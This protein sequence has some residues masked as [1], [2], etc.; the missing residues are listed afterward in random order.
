MLL[1]H[2]QLAVLLKTRANVSLTQGLELGP[3]CGELLRK[4]P[5]RWDWARPSGPDLVGCW[6]WVREDARGATGLR[7]YALEG[8][9]ADVLGAGGRRRWC[10]CVGSSAAARA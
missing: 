5:L 4:M 6:S 8:R 1:R 10:A 3:V 2:V 9:I 7:L